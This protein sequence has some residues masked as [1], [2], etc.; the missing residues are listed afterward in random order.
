MTDPDEDI[1]SE[2]VLRILI[3]EDCDDGNPTAT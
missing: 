2:A 1:F 3:E